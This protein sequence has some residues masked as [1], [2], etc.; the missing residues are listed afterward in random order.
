MRQAKSQYKSHEDSRVSKTPV[1]V[2]RGAGRRERV[3]ISQ[4]PRRNPKIGLHKE[5][6]NPG[7]HS[8]EERYR[9]RASTPRRSAGI[10]FSGVVERNPI[11][12]YFR[13]VGDGDR[14]R[15]GRE[16]DVFF[17]NMVREVKRRHEVGV[18]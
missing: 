6:V 1:P 2:G 16:V 3:S 13:K 12:A 18:G 17:D 14:E 4:S 9:F 8:A 11:G 15:L 5:L 7:L 10:G